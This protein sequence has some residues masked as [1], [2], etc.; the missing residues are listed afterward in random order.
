MHQSKYIIGNWKMNK[1]I[2]EARQFILDLSPKIKQTSHHIYLAVPFTVLQTSVEAA[3]KSDIV[4]GTQNVSEFAPGP[5]TGEIAAT[6]IR[7]SGAFFTLV[8]H[9]E[10]RRL[11]H[12]NGPVINAKIKIALA[13][14]LKV[15][16]CIGETLDER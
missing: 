9:S 10:R 16:L 13:A 1:T 15:I 11:F 3:Q 2:A 12:E 7:D 4:I 14:G 5:Y 6:M 8:G